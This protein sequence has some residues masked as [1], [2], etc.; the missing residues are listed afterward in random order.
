ARLPTGAR[1]SA[2]TMSIN[3]SL[4]AEALRTFD[5]LLEQA[6][7]AG[8]PEP[9]AMTLATADP[10]GRLSARVV[11]LK[12]H[13]ARGLVFYTNTLSRKG[14]A[15][16]VNPRAAVLFHWKTLRDQVQVRIEGLVESVSDTE[17][18]AYFAT[19]P[20]ESQ[21]GAWASLQSEALPDRSAFE[22]RY[23]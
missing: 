12:A 15:L 3:D 4:H 19:R 10:D 18:D 2:T 16:A 8:D 1:L 21:L 23:A 14:L 5:D 9:T 6:R 11:L 7:V 17:A 13:D 22:A 20:R